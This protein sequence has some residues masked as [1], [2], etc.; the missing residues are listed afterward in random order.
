MSKPFAVTDQEFD[1]EVLQSGT[2][3]L[4]DFWAEWCQ[5][6]KMIAPIVDAL[7]EEYDGKIRFAKVDVDSNPQTPMNYGIRGIPTLIIFRGGE[8]VE[9]VVGAVPKAELKR[10]LESVLTQA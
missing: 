6:C 2:P 8:A 1:L 7:A 5:P 9:Q 3:V 10:R 4:V